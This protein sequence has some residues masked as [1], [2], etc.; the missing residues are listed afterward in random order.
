[1]QLYLKQRIFTWFDSFD[2][3]H[4]DGSVAYTVQGQLSWGHK[5]EVQDDEGRYLGMV[6]QRALTFL[7]QFEMYRGDEYLGCI[8]REF[9]IL[10]STF[11]LD[12]LG[13]SA[14]G[15]MLGWDYELRDG[16]VN[17]YAAHDV[18]RYGRWFDDYPMNYSDS[19]E[20]KY[21]GRA[22]EYRQAAGLSYRVLDDNV[23]YVRCAS[24]SSG[25]GEGNLAQVMADLS[26]CDGLIVDV[27]SNGGGQLTYAARLASA[28]I[29]K[30][31]LGGYMS[32]KTGP[33]HADLSTPEPVWL[34][35][36]AG[37]RW[38]KP[39]A[40]LTNRR[41]YSAANTFVMYM[42]G[43]PGVTIVGDRTG[44]GAGM[45]LNAELPS[46][47]LV[48]FSACPMYDRDGQ[49]TEMG[50]DPDVKVDITSEDY[51]RSVDTI[52]ETARRLLRERAAG[53]VSGS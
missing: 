14:D 15:D 39:V 46:G 43:L 42:K 9:T 36:F 35:P 37:L 34:D 12:F 1:M 45:P 30:R 32:H 3:Y 33:G 31:T 29:D 8:Y 22:D 17:L 41:T 52:I 44:G 16:H 25:F 21:L 48:R 20:R 2:I 26:L 13:W 40:V 11:T 5:L 49:I 23:G 10:R 4:E 38:Q 24:F 19:L 6:R 47:W 27:R 28:F 18:A 53:G 7:P 51:A 50:I